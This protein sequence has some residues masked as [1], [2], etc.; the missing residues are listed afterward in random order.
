M[1]LL[2]C[3][4]LQC[5][6]NCICGS[7]CLF[8]YL[9]IF[10]FFFHFI[11]PFTSFMSFSIRCQSVYT[12]FLFSH[13]IRNKLQPIEELSCEK[14]ISKPITLIGLFDICFFTSFLHF[15]LPSDPDNGFLFISISFA[16]AIST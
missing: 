12:L 11:F 1:N 8:F 16:R 4:R 9:F 10:Y 15:Y 6:T 3:I 14:F 2:E 7:S 5:L 13:L